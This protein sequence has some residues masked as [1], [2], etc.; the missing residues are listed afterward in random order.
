MQRLLPASPPSLGRPTGRPH[1]GDAPPEHHSALRLH[2]Q[3]AGPAAAAGGC[4]PLNVCASRFAFSQH[5]HAQQILAFRSM[6]K[7]DRFEFPG[8]P[9][10]FMTT[11]SCLLE[12]APVAPAA[13]PALVEGG[14]LPPSAD[15]NASADLLALRRHRLAALEPATGAPEQP[16]QEASTAPPLPAPPEADAAGSEG[17]DWQ[18]LPTPPPP[19]PVVISDDEEPAPRP[20]CAAP[21]RVEPTECGICLDACANRGAHQLCSL[22]CGHVFGRACIELWLRKSANSRRCPHCKAACR[23]KD[24]RPLYASSVVAV[25]VDELEE[26]RARAERL[27]AELLTL[28]SERASA[29]AAAAAERASHAQTLAALARAQSNLL[30]ASG[31]APHSPLQTAPLPAQAWRHYGIV[32]TASGADAL[33]VLPDLVVTARL[34]PA[35]GVSASPSLCIASYPGPK[36]IRMAVPGVT[37]VY[38]IQLARHAEQTL[39]LLACS[40]RLALVSLT[41]CM[42]VASAVT[43]QAVTC[44]AWGPEGSDEGASPKGASQKLPVPSVGLQSRSGG[45]TKPSGCLRASHLPCGL[46]RS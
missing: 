36:L 19:S 14:A 46:P 32:T 39:A 27:Q 18:M 1:V 30:S 33:A 21:A 11:P 35:P 5:A 7:G 17:D 8:Q 25:D 40:S 13:L 16:R 12:T 23:V 15:G 29:S 22:R 9:G 34:F 24:V 6:R 43:P 31:R 38:D 4:L 10:R 37:A 20:A 42:E 28:R 41:Q 3:A 44:C 45:R 26:Q 2:G